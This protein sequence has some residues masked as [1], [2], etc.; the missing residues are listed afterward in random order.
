MY[1][2]FW[3]MAQCIPLKS[4]DVSEGHVPSNF[5]YLLPRGFLLGL[6]FDPEVGGDIFLRDVGNFQRTTR[7]FI[8]E[9]RTLHTHICKNLK[10]C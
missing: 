8:L 4:T 10:F 3:D 2:I 6:F 9:D 1:Y 7:R 5:C